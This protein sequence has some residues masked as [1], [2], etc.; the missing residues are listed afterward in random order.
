MAVKPNAQDWTIKEQ[1]IEDPVTGLTFQF[2][3]N[4]K[5]PECPMRFVI[6]GAGP[7]GNREYLFD[8]TGAEAGSGTAMG[9]VCRPNWLQG[10]E[11][12]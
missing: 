8:V 11:G 10:V 4:D 6:Y 3:V 5:A 2:Y 7:F 1:I 9:G 12:S